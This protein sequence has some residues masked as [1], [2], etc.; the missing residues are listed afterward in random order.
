MSSFTQTN[1]RLS[2]M[3]PV[4]KQL[5]KSLRGLPD[6]LKQTCEHT[7]SHTPDRPLFKMISREDPGHTPDL[8]GEVPPVSRVGEDS[9]RNPPRCRDFRVWVWCRLSR[10]SEHEGPRKDRDQRLAARGDIV[11]GAQH[12]GWGN[13]QSNLFPGFPDRGCEQM[14]IDG[15]AA[16]AG[17][18]HVTGPG[19]P[20][21]FGPANNQDGIGIRSDDEGNGSLANLRI[22]DRDWDP[23]VKP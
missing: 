4:A 15:V 23:T 5:R 13:R 14:L 21:A 18:P 12:L 6:N 10:N 19:V 1:Y 20:T 2:S 7:L 22:A 11:E 9:E 17:K 16:A 8:Q 3:P